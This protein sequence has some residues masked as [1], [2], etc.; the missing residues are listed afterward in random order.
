MLVYSHAL[1]EF[2]N[3]RISNSKLLIDKNTLY[4]R[5]IVRR[6]VEVS[7]HRDK[8]AIDINEDNVACLLVD[9]DKG[10][11]VLFTVNHNISRLRE[12]YRRIGRSI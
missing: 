4:I 11:A 3:A 12:N 8:L 10:R 5:L 9:Y 6:N 1:R 2:S 7:E